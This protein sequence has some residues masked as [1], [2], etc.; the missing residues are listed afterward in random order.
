MNRILHVKASPR[1]S[2]SFSIR[3]AEAFLDSFL[4]AHRDFKVQTL[5][6]FATE[7]PEFCAPAAKA[8]YAILAGG[9]PRDEAEA[10]WKPVIQLVEHFKS[11]DAYLISSP[12]WNFGIPYRLKQY[13]DVLVQPGLT[14]TYSPEEG[15]SGLVTG[16]PLVLVLARGGAYGEGSGAEPFDM[17]KL[18]LE[19]IFAFIG[20]TDIRTIIVEPT[21]QEGPEAARLALQNAQAEAHRLAVE[22]P[23]PS[24]A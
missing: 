8:K 1:G 9:E 22:L 20:F 13:V 14:F 18:Y 7:L 11:A 23:I 17:Q 4:Q 5:D 6:L 24:P 10:A 16:K 19:T 2:E 12:M 3:A 21:L 15:Y